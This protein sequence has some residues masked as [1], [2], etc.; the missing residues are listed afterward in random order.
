MRAVK[1]AKC[2]TSSQ[3][4]WYD[5][6]SQAKGY[7]HDSKTDHSKSAGINIGYFLISFL[8]SKKPEHHIKVLELET[9]MG[10][11]CRV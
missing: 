3:Y 10:G 7:L 4:V 1:N 6:F 2:L 5:E 11:S 8:D 9:D